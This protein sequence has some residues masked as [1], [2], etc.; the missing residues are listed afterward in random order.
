MPLFIYWDRFPRSCCP[1]YLQ[2]QIS[3]KLDMTK[4]QIAIA[5]FL[6]V[7][8]DW[9]WLSIGQSS[10]PYK[11]SWLDW[12]IARMEVVILLV[13]RCKR[14]SAYY[15]TN[16][17]SIYRTLCLQN[18]SCHNKSLLQNST[19]IHETISQDCDAMFL[20][21]FSCQRLLWWFFSCYSELILANSEQKGGPKW[22]HFV[23]L[24][25]ESN[26]FAE[27]LSLFVFV[28]RVIGPGTFL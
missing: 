28:I 26:F 20:Y 5:R 23:R 16:V 4:G 25:R 17:P 10:Y 27:L 21:N 7:A 2:T 12:A 13:Q 19:L 18:S 1:W 8:F 22:V 24:T 9:Y 15:E 11:H 3:I 6:Q 14:Q